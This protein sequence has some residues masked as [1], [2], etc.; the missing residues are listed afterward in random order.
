MEMGPEE[1]ARWCTAN[2]FELLTPREGARLFGVRDAT[3]R[4]A[5]SE[6]KIHPVFK[7][8]AVRDLPLYKLSDLEAYFAGRSKADPALLATMRENGITCY[9]KGA[10]GWLLLCERPGLGTWGEAAA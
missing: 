9:L 4:T 8:A 10:G 2:R 5:A 7:L 3:V 1:L 6:G